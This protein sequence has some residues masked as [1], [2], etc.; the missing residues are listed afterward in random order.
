MAR[1]RKKNNFGATIIFRTEDET[2]DALEVKARKYKSLAAFLQTHMRHIA[3]GGELEAPAM[4]VRKRKSI[5]AAST[6]NVN[7][8]SFKSVDRG[9]ETNGRIYRVKGHKP[10]I[11]T[12][13][14][15]KLIR[16][17]LSREQ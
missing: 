6:N 15:A 11:L 17:K 14:A 9:I 2:K 13:A 7:G 8:D 3:F 12:L 1:K 5:Q 16:T 10:D 4:R